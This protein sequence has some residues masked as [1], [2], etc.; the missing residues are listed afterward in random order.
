MTQRGAT[1]QNQEKVKGGEELQQLVGMSMREEHL[2]GIEGQ[3]PGQ[4]L[5][6]LD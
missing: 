5:L 6:R 4:H 2:L 1:T 3:G